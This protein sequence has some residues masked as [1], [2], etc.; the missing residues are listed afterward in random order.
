[1]FTPW[2]ISMRKSTRI[3]QRLDEEVAARLL[4]LPGNVAGQVQPNMITTLLDNQTKVRHTDIQQNISE[5]NAR[6]FEEE[7]DK[8]DG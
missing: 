3:G 1:M 4:T 5:R 2:L 6:F 7:A 8:L